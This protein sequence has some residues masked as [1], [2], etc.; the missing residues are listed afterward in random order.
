MI[1]SISLFFLIYKKKNFFN[2]YQKD[3]AI[4]IFPIIFFLTIGFIYGE[5]YY[6]FRGNYWDYFN[7]VSSALLYKDY[8]YSEVLLLQQ[9]SD[10]PLFFQTAIASQTSRPLV[11]LMMSYFYNLKFINIFLLSYSFK[12]FVISLS[13]IGFYCFLKNFFKK[14]N[15]KKY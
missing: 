12:I 4:T 8:N 7:Y 10:L 1:I 9:K 6:V 13:T 11:M 3:F 2:Q 5:Q 15:F 14:I